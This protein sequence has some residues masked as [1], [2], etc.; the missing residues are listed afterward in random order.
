[1]RREFLGLAILLA[2]V[3]SGCEEVAP[4]PQDTQPAAQPATAQPPQTAAQQTAP[5]QQA[6]AQQ[7]PAQQAAPGTA[8]IE[9]DPFAKANSEQPDAGTVREKARRGMGK[10]GQGY[11]GGIITQPIATYFQTRDR[12]AFAVQIPHSM[13][14]YKAMNGRY[15]KDLDEFMDKIIRL[16]G[17]DLPELPDGHRYV[18]DPKKGELLVERPR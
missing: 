13:K 2:L 6:P 3:T 9:E 10:K 11:G 18:Y 5:A 15:P 12:I 4:P 1:M 16:A 17:I 8:I 7:A 14:L